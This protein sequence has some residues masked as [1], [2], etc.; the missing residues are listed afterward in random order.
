MHRCLLRSLLNTPFSATVSLLALNCNLCIHDRDRDD[1]WL[2][3]IEKI[4]K[5]KVL[6][7]TILKKS[8]V[9]PAFV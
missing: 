6:H 7:L 3:K 2:A 8:G 4:F 9:S 5:N 1:A